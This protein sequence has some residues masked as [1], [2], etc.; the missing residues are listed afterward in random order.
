MPAAPHM[1]SLLSCSVWPKHLLWN[2]Q[3][4]NVSQNIQ[5]LAFKYL[6]DL[7][8]FSHL[9]W[10]SWEPCG[11]L[12]AELVSMNVSKDEVSQKKWRRTDSCINSCRLYSRYSPEMH[13]IFYV[14]WKSLILS[15]SFLQPT[16]YSQS[17]L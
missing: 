6:T 1:T 7:W 8:L 11:T 5:K 9:F 3:I 14:W 2:I 12:L 4:R 13:I 15:A 10:V 17:A 16:K